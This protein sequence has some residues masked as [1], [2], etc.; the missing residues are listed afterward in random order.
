[1][2]LSVTHT[3]VVAVADDGTSPVGSDDWNAAHTISGTVTA[4]QGGF[5]ADVSAQSGVPLF[6]SG[7]ATFTSTTGT[8]NFVRATSPTLV[9]PALGT[10]SA[11]VLTNA[12]GLPLTTGVTGN[13]PVTNL[14][15]GTSASN[16]TFWRGD[17]TWATP[18]A[19]GSPAGASLT[20]QYNNASAFGGMSGTSWDDTNRSLTLTGATVTTSNPVFNLTQTWNA[21]AVTFTGFK[22]NVTSTAS[23]AASLL[24][25]LQ[26]GSASKFSVDKAGAVIAAGTSPAVTLGAGGSSS[27]VLFPGAGGSLTVGRADDYPNARASMGIVTSSAATGFITTDTGKYIWSNSATDLN[28]GDTAILRIAA[29]LIEINNNTTAGV[30]YLRLNGVAVASLP[31]ASATYKGARGTV[32]DSNATLTAGI[33]AVVA[34]GGANVVPVFC[35]GTNWRIG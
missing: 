21:G 33:G 10:P 27:P 7:T 8:G 1:M 12:T 35:D 15:S 6:A 14:G 9:T 30:A 5:G 26:V 17:G 20:I 32:T 28:T 16:T 23:A 25:D 24:M 18:A 11:A 13:L 31:A 34:N 2:A 19:G 3:T 4:A 29:A 22:L